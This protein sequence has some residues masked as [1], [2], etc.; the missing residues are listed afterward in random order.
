MSMTDR[1]T[2]TLAVCAIAALAIILWALSI[3]FVQRDANRK[4]LPGYQQVIWLVLAALFPFV[5]A[6]AYLF[7]R[8]LDRF[9]SPPQERRPVPRGRITADKRPEN[10]GKRMPTIAAADLSRQT[11]VDLTPITGDARARGRQAARERA[12]LSLH[13]LAGPLAGRRFAIQSLPA[14]IGR[15]PLAAIRLDDD[16]GVSRQHAEI[17]ENAGLLRIRDLKSSHGTYL[18]GKNIT[19][20]ILNPGDQLSIGLSTVMFMV[21][22]QGGRS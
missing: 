1:L 22:D 21:E 6:L 15:G 7:A 5:G 14:R 17:Y 4:N 16:P 19:D 2:N 11:V 9:F 18:N 8:E 3:A 12:G 20:E 10:P 13:F